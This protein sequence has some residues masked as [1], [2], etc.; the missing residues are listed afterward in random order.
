MEA[1]LRLFRKLFGKQDVADVLA[2]F[3]DVVNDLNAIA[4]RENQRAF[5]LREEAAELNEQADGAIVEA[6]KARVA[7]DKVRR[8]LA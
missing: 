6:G 1:L 7:A 5:D 8:L 4:G 2:V 3:S